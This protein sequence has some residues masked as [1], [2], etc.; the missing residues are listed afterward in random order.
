[1]LTLFYVFAT[2]DWLSPLLSL[3]LRT[4]PYYCRVYFASFNLICIT[5]SRFLLGRV[6]LS[7][8]CSARFGPGCRDS[9]T[10]QTQTPMSHNPPPRRFPLT[11]C[12][13]SNVP[14]LDAFLTRAGA[15]ASSRG[16]IPHRV[17]VFLC[18]L[19]HF[20]KVKCPLQRLHAATHFPVIPATTSFLTIPC[21]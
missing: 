2:G 19:C 20:S 8:F 11:P 6:L 16:L 18:D 21:R 14:H 9:A 13:A 4:Y 5:K 10:N 15:S 12:T 3:P 1:M 17:P 7:G